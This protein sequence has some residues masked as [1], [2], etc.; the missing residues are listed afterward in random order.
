[1]ME[2]Q[3]TQRKKRVHMDDVVWLH[4][5]RRFGLLKTRNLTHSF[6]SYQVEGGSW[7]AEWIENDEYDL[8]EERATEYESE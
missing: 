4:E 7:E 6:I 1:M 8:W 3:L 5:H 2:Y